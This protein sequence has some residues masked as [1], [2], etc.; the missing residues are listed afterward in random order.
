MDN[1]FVLI[2]I[3]RYGLK[4]ENTTVNILSDNNAKNTKNA[5]NAKNAENNENNKNEPLKHIYIK[6]KKA[7]W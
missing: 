5:E 1:A 4:S 2:Y 7:S 3:T 6:K